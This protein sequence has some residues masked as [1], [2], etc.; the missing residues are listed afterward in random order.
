[1]HCSAD[2]IM[3]G[4]T[5]F[6][7][8]QLGALTLLNRIIMA[9]L[10]RMRARMPGNVPWELN[11]EYYRQRA[12]A[13]LIITEATPV[14]PCGHGYFNTPGIHTTAQMQGWR[15]VTEAV[16]NAGGRIFL[17]LWH[18]GRQ[19]HND[20]QPGGQ[21]PVAP[22]AIAGSGQSAISPG[23]SKD[24]PVPRALETEEIPKVVEEFRHGAELGKQAGFDGVE[25]HGANGYLIEQFLTDGANHRTDQYGGTVANRARFLWEVIEAVTSVWPSERVGLRL[26][27][28]STFGGTSD[29][30]R[31]EIFSYVVKEVNRFHLSYLHFVEPRVNGSEDSQA[32]DGTLASRNFRA[33]IQ[34]DTRLIS[35]GRHTLESGSLALAKGEADAIAYGR[36]FLANPDLPRRFA[37]GAPLNTPELS[38]FYGGDEKGYTDYPVLR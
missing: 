2:F 23:V 38:M 14:S 26:S 37:S 12:S 35:A 27:P 36:L 15:L 31:R 17:Q 19:S 4:A 6:E 11:A 3:S 24:H 32:Y 18:V 7:P 13:G 8:L 20:L 28:A 22:S 16:H 1:M 34:G 10:T 25:I 5:L 21:A 29:S 30:N 9:P 33:L